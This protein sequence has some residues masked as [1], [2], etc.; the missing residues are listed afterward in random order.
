MLSGQPRE[1]PYSAPYNPHDVSRDTSQRSQQQPQEQPPSPARKSMFEYSS[2]FDAMPPVKKKPVPAQPA[3]SSSGNEGS[4]TTASMASTDPKRKPGDLLEQFD[5]R[6]PASTNVQA[7]ND[8]YYPYAGEEPESRVPPS[9]P[10][11]LNPSASPSPPRSQ[12]QAASR[13]QRRS[14][15]SPVSQAGAAGSNRR[16]K[17]SAPGTFKNGKGAGVKNKNQ[18]Y[19][20]VRMLHSRIFTD[21]RNPKDATS[22]H[23]VRRLSAFGGYSSRPRC[24]TV[25]SYRFSQAGF[26]LLA[27]HHHRCHTLGGICNDERS[28]YLFLRVSSASGIRHRSCTCDLASQW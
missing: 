16:D 8:P 20:C 17:E 4:W 9:L 10:S 23:F 15:D 25:H 1:E 22:D 13:P 11:K 24:S 28:V 26:R 6:G 3:S 19:L 5:N 12:A 18:G 7:Q 2:P 14:A 27:R 21:L